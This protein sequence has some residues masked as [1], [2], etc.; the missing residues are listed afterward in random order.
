L[1]G[2]SLARK[3]WLRSNT[4][5]TLF[6]PIAWIASN[7]FATL[8]KN[9]RVRGSLNLHS[10]PNRMSRE[11]ANFSHPFHGVAPEGLVVG[12]EWVA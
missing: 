1:A 8:L 3:E 7:V 12:L 6:T 5:P 11:E 9:M 10:I 4:I 2:V